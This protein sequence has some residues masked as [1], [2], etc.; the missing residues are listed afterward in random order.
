M[1]EVTT[2]QVSINI[3]NQN[4][5]RGIGKKSEKV[6]YRIHKR[7]ENVSLKMKKE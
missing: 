4:Q 6:M 5:L 7:V 1:K 3:W 2:E